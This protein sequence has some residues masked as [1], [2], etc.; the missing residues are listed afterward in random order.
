MCSSA[1]PEV[2]YLLHFDQ[3]LWNR[4]RAVQHYIGWAP[5]MFAVLRRLGQHQQGNK[6]HG[7]AL[8]AAVSKAG[9]GMHI[10]RAWEAPPGEGRGL[11]R[12]KKNRHGGRWVWC[13]ECKGRDE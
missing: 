10:V 5:N 7:A 6:R 4:G 12:R 13:P 8:T 9:I 3:P 1:L 11:E 2:V